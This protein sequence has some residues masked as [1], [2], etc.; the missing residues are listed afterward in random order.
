MGSPLM[1][2]NASVKIGT[3]LIK[4]LGKWSVNIQMDNI[5]VT[6]FGSVWKKEMPGFQGWSGSV[7]GYFDPADTTGQKALV[8]AGLAATKLTDLRFYL[9]NTSYYTPDVTGDAEAGAFITGVQISHDK[10]GVAQVT[11]NVSGFGGLILV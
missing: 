9:D 11:F 10:A 3:N 2:R 6:A 5:D 7:E 4:N 8:D 1:G